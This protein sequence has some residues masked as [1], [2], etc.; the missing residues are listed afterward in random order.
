MKDY[1]LNRYL[2]DIVDAVGDGIMI[3][4]TDGRIL[5]VNA[6]MVRMTGFP[7]NEMIGSPW[8]IGL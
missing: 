8:R 3:V 4:D 7:E 2:K 6:A 1:K 5:M